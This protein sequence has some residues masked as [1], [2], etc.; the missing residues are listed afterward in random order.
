MS[1]GKH[2]QHILIARTPGIEEEEEEHGLSC[3]SSS[4]RSRRDNNNNN[5]YSTSAEHKAIQA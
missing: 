1:W 4:S 2:R 3:C 5:K